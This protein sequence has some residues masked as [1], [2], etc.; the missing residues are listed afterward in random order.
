[1]NPYEQLN[2]A[3]RW[4]FEHPGVGLLFTILWMLWVAI[5]LG[6]ICLQIY[7]H[8]ECEELKKIMRQF[9][10]ERQE[11]ERKANPFKSETLENTD[12]RYM[13]RQ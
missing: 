11:R 7:K 2:P 8:N 5:A 12:K 10:V 9:D 1:M 13:P 3:L 6:F 4:L